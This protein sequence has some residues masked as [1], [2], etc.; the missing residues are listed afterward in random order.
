ME[1][2]EMQNNAG[3]LVI[4]GCDVVELAMQWGTPL[5]VFDEELAANNARMYREALSSLP[6]YEIIF[7]GKALLT[8]GIARFMTNLGLS[9]DVVSG[10]E[11]YIALTAG[12]PAQR[13]FFHGNNK[14]AADLGTALDLGVG[15]IVVDNLYELELLS[16][17]AQKKKRTADILLRI[18]PG[19]EAH[20]HSYIQT[21]QLDSKFG[22]SVAHNQAIDAV[23]LACSL[24]GLRLRGVH[25]HIGSQIFE[26]AS[27]AKT[28]DVMMSLIAEA[29]ALGIE[30]TELNLGGGLGIKYIDGDQPAS[31][32]DFGA[33][34]TGALKSAAAKYNLRLPK[35]MVEP[36]RSLVGAA[37]TTVYRIGSIKENKGSRTYAAVNGGMA[38][39]P[40]VALYQAKYRAVVANKMDQAPEHTYTIVGQFCES[41]DVL[42][43]SIELP[44]LEPGDLLAVFCT[45]AYNYA[46]ASNFN[47][48]P[49]M[50]IVTVYRGQSDLVV[51]RETYQDLIR[52]H[53]IPDRWLK[54]G[55]EGG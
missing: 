21:G 5:S 41:S 18:M 36:G 35:I 45:G 2:R 43:N 4:G 15:R 7:A 3:H 48:V 53:R 22:I 30:L 6:E 42:I 34:L 11:L 20:T 1:N 44:Q 31:I 52:L 38:D 33:Y 40:R 8:V 27:Y 29:E 12:V 24:P 55:V 26:L 46:M 9:L 49:R 32:R 17:L 10:G 23:K 14:T 50:P 28:I 51:E 39:N 37:G 25:C 16:D 54:D 19:V 47:A 13:I